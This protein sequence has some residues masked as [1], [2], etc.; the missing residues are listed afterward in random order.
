MKYF[1]MF[2]SFAIMGSSCITGSKVTRNKDIQNI[3]QSVAIT[4]PLTIY[5]VEEKYFDKVAIQLSNDGNQILSYPSPIDIRRH[6][7][8]PYPTRL[9]EGYLLDNVGNISQQ[10]AFLSMSY[11]EYATLDK[12]PSLADMKRMIV[13]KGVKE[14]YICRHIERNEN[15]KSKINQ[16]IAEQ[17]L[18]RLCNSE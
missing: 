1:I 9:N 3:E 13:G 15:L 8:L 5:K 7:Q 18:N 17:S 11:E 16:L 12:A 14:I 10:T 2:I 6:E 4:S